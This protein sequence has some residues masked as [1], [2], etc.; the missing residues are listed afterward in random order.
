MPTRDLYHNIV[1]EAL[2]KDGWIITNDPLYLRL[3]DTTFE[4]DLG[5]EKMLGAEKNGE[6]IAVEIKSFVAGSPVAEFQ[7]AIGQLSMYKIALEKEKSDRQLYLAIS[8]KIYKNFINHLYFSIMI[9]IHNI[10]LLIF[11]HQKAEVIQWIK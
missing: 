5:A 1:I 11:D 8:N 9:K 7:R 10:S 3:G 6:R 2:Q 4:A